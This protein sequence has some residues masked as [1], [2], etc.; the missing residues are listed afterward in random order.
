MSDHLLMFFDP[1]RV[2]DDELAVLRRR[3]TYARNIPYAAA[4]GLPATYFAL[5]HFFLKRHFNIPLAVALGVFGYLYV[6]ETESNSAMFNCTSF[7]SGYDLKT[8]R[9]RDLLKSHLLHPLFRFCMQ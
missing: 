2:T 6:A 9:D 1:D 7:K 8:I 5:N 3:I 4:A